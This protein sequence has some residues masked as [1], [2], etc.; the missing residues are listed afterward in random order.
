MRTIE[1][2]EN[3]RGQL[4]TSP[5]KF[6][7]KKMGLKGEVPPTNYEELKNEIKLW[8]RTTQN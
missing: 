5:Q 6:F 3:I 1:V 8:P 4:R 2:Q 7:E